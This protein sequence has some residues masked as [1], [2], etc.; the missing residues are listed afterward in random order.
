[1]VMIGTTTTYH[2]LATL[3]HT[4][5]QQVV[6]LIFTFLGVVGWNNSSDSGFYSQPCSLASLAR[7]L[8]KKGWMFLWEGW[9]V[10]VKNE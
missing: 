6:C 5:Q 2:S 4:S 3:A 9:P 1:M 10:G 7:K 8:A